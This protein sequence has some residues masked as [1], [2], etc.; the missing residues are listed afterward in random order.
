M[1]G[2]NQQPA[3]MSGRIWQPKRTTKINNQKQWTKLVAE[4]SGQKYQPEWV[5]KISGQN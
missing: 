4:M 2:R 1:N 5:V 3:E